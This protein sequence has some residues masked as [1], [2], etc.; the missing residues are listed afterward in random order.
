MESNLIIT[1]LILA[2]V[3]VS[4]VQKGFSLRCYTCYS[5][6]SWEDCFKRDDY[7]DCQKLDWSRDT[8]MVCSNV[9]VALKK[10]DDQQ[11]F[12]FSASCLPKSP[13]GCNEEAKAKC[14]EDWGLGGK[15]EAVNCE[16]NCCETDWCNKEVSKGQ[17]SSI[18]ILGLIISLLSCY[19]FHNFWISMSFLN[20]HSSSSEI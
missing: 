11:E 17:V 14:K 8:K 13:Q 4:L 19:S 5:A 16:V 18:S 9:F 12:R 7:K 15:Y 2:V 1:S 3:F 6:I 10:K 20:T